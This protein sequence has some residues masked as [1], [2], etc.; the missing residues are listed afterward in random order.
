MGTRGAFG[1]ISKGKTKVTY[2]HYD[3]YPTGLGVS[4]IKACIDYPREQIA[5]AA[6]AITLVKEDKKPTKAQ[7][8]KCIAAGL[9][10]FNVSTRSENDWYCLLRNL[11]GDIESF[12]SGRAPFM[13]DSEAFLA[14]SL[15]C[16]WAYIINCDTGNLEVYQGFNQDPKAPGRYA[17]L[18]DGE[19]CGVKLLREIPLAQLRDKDGVDGYAQWLA[20]ELEQMASEGEEA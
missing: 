16:E 15:F 4:V 18:R 20:D 12:V 11:Q 17:H 5:A 8:K 7:I 1:F 10:D 2:N 19:Y 14:D 6:D 13:I 9:A 3:S